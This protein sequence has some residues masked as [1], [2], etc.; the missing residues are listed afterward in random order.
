M[1]SFD[2]IISKWLSEIGIRVSG[3]YLKQQLQTHPDYPSMLCITDTLESLGI[4]HAAVQIDKEQ[5]PEIPVPFLAHLTGNGGEWVMVKSRD[6]LDQQFPH[7]YDRWKGTVLAAEKTEGWRNIEN[8]R[9]LEKERIG[10]YL[11]LIFAGILSIIIFTALLTAGTILDAGL[12]MSAL[13]GI[14]I[15]WLIETKDLGIDNILADQV[16]GAKADCNAVIHSKASKLPGGLSWGDIGLIWFTFQFLFLLN[17]VLSENTQEANHLLSLCALLYLPFT[18]F[19]LFYQWRVAKKWCRLCLIVVGIILVQFALLLPNILINGL[20]WPGYSTSA[21]A[22]LL[23]I[24]GII[25]WLSVKRLFVEKKQL[26]MDK[27]GLQRFKNNTDI[28]LAL[29]LKQRRVDTSAWERELQIGNPSGDVQITVACNPYCG[30]CAKAH[31]VLNNLVEVDKELGLTV[32]FTIYSSIKEDKK[33]KAVEFIYQLIETRRAISTENELIQYQ[34][35]LLNDGFEWMDFEKFKSKYSILRNFDVN[36]SLKKH[37]TWGRETNIK[38]TPT[39]FLNGYELPKVY[40]IED[41]KFMIRAMKDSII[42]N[43]LQY[44]SL[45]IE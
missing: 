29:L 5:L 24:I 41:L 25:G 40:N 26:E 31:Q 37:E 19:S 12:L 33:T 22:I 44:S 18:S 9:E 45:R 16:C 34:K 21:T 42:E 30:P 35:K 13:A 27:S 2:T 15:C 32:R 3:K 23:L 8:E 28:F 36:D 38:F 10:K 39:I 20:Q 1:P 6:D 14:L 17:S 43:R 7:F 4:E 11:V